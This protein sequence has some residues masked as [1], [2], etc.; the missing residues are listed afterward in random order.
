MPKISVIVPVYNVGKT[1]GKC[2]DSL[3]LQTFKDIEIICVDDC[4]TDGSADILE[5]Y[6]KKDQRI[7]ILHNSSNQG[8]GLTRN[9]GVEYATGEYIHFLDSDDWM[10]LNAYETLVNSVN[11]NPDVICFLW[12]NFDVRNNNIRPEKFKTSYLVENFNDNPSILDDWGISVWHRIYRREFLKSENIIF[13]DYRCFEDIEYIYKVLI[14]A[15]K[16]VFVNKNLI[17][18]RINNPNSLL[19]KSFSFYNCAIDSYNTIYEYSKMLNSDIREILLAKLLNSLLYK[20][21]GSFTVGVLD[22]S[23]LK[24]IVSN[25]D[26]SIFK[27]EKKSYK[28]YIYYNE[29]MNYPAFIIKLMYKFRQYLRNNFYCLYNLFA[30]I[31]EKIRI[32]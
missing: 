10:E 19:G 25:L 8:L 21:V 31:K 22:Y 12:N 26:L 5:E 3:I 17:N 16:I 23:S 24:S 1:L 27:L 6:S 18:Y 14:T 20:L 32:K 15:K 7:K 2:L 28:W 4:S 13:N 9:H 11:D 30:G 29:V